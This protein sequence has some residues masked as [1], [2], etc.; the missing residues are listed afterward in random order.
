MKEIAIDGE[1]GHLCSE[2]VDH[3][4]DDLPIRNNE[5]DVILLLVQDL[6]SDGVGSDEPLLFLIGV[7]VEVVVL[8]HP[9]VVRAGIP[10]GGVEQFELRVRVF[11]CVCVCV[12]VCACVRVCVCVRV[13]ACVRV[14]AR[15]SRRCN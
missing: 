9:T 13:C 4:G 8:C 12:R 15:G 3:P 2:G 10:C 1:A 11:H 5:G 7:G 14:G 6:E